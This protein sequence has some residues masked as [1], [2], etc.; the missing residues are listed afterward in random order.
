MDEMRRAGLEERTAL[1]RS[2]ARAR[3]S[4]RSPRRARA[5]APRRR[6]RSGAARSRT[7][8]HSRPRP[9]DRI[10]GRRAVVDRRNPSTRD[11]SQPP[12]P[13]RYLRRSAPS[14]LACVAGSWPRRRPRGWPG[15][16]RSASGS[17]TPRRSYAIGGLTAEADGSRKPTICQARQL[18]GARR[19]ARLL[20]PQRRCATYLPHAERDGAAGSGR[21]GG[22]AV[23]E[24]SGS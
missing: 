12:S 3:P 9:P 22:P 15:S 18:R 17:G 16:L 11:I 20:P 14:C 24:P 2:D 10:L 5:A 19:R 7:R 6:R 1:R 23:G 4:R 13:R 21:R 8:T